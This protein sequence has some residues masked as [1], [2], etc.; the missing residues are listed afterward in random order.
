MSSTLPQIFMVFSA[1]SAQCLPRSVRQD[2]R[3]H[4]DPERALAYVQNF[5]LATWQDFVRSYLGRS[6]EGLVE[7]ERKEQ[8]YSKEDHQKRLEA[9]VSGWDQILKI[10]EEEL[11]SA[12]EL[13]SYLRAIGAPVSPL[14]IGISWEHTR[15]AFLVS[16]DIRKKYNASW[17]LWDLGQADDVV[18]SLWQE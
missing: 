6:G 9:I 4:P 2:Q 14:E 16:R 3:A 1:A 17:L 5:D 15:K 12:Q 10:V 13:R 8:K 11:P 18:Q 7:Q